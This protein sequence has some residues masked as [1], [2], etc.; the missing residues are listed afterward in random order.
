MT[1]QTINKTQFLEYLKKKKLS[2]ND[3]TKITV[4]KIAISGTQTISVVELSLVEGEI[5]KSVKWLSKYQ[6]TI[7]EKIKGKVGI[8]ADSFG[9]ASAVKFA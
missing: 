3:V 7:P 1:T 4:N 8:Y 2:S 9:T 5:K 6:K